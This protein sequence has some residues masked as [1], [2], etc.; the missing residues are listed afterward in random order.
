MFLKEEYEVKGHRTTSTLRCE[1]KMFLCIEKCIGN[2]STDAF[3]GESSLFLYEI[4]KYLT[5]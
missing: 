5:S 1:T 2:I 4:Q 3:L